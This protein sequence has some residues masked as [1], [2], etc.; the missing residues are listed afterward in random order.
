MSK[1]SK[2][3]FENEITPSEN[4]SE[5][6]TQTLKE[7]KDNVS[8]AGFVNDLDEN[9]EDGNKIKIFYFFQI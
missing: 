2:I 1:I 5:I 7:T 8:D 9:N 6:K 4:N 3:K